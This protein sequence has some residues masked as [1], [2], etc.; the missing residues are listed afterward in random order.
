[1]NGTLKFGQTLSIIFYLLLLLLFGINKLNIV[2][3]KFIW[4]IY[5]YI[6]I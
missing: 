3:I 6:Y 4:N 1:M 5:I 2:N